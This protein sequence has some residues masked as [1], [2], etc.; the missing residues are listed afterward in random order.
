M[1]LWK[2]FRVRSPALPHVPPAI[3]TKHF[4]LN[5][6]FVT[7]AFRSR[8]RKIKP[9]LGNLVPFL[10]KTKNQCIGVVQYVNKKKLNN[11]HFQHK[12]KNLHLYGHSE[13]QHK[14]WGSGSSIKSAYLVSMRPWVQT[15][16]LQ[17]NETRRITYQSHVFLNRHLS[18]F[19]L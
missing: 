19:F 11:S 17:K 6:L 4:I 15:P 7:P 2:L 16:V 10:Q 14:S 12:E 9:S 18:S 3:S 13:A 5:Y 8:G 1:I